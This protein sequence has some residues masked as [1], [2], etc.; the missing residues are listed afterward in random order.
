MKRLKGMD[1]LKVAGWQ[2]NDWLGAILSLKGDMTLCLD[3]DA[4]LLK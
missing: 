1:L 4:R 2:L 3:Y